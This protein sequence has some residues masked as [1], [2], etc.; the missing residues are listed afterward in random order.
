MPSFSRSAIIGSAYALALLAAMGLSAGAQAQTAHR[1][2]HHKIHTVAPRAPDFA[3]GTELHASTYAAPGS[4][5]H[6]YSDTVASGR[7]DLMDLS[8][9]YG[10]S[11]TVL[12][13][14][15]EPLFKF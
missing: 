15:A 10:Q 9:R 8:Y 5:N 6:Y 1:T 14:S 2:V 11:P 7:A 13:N 3:P 4:E 12:Y